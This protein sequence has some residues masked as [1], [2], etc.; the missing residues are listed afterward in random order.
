MRIPKE[1]REQ[2][3]SRA[4]GYCEDCGIDTYK[5]QL[6]HLHYNTK[7]RERP[8]DLLALCESCHKKKHYDIN[9]DYWRDPEEMAIYWAKYEHDM[10]KDD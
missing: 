10:A 9:G 5:L 8:C 7:G 1:T 2:V 3:R 6:H 4:D